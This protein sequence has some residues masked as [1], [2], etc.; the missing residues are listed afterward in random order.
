MSK[1]STKLHVSF[2]M[3]FNIKQI[4]IKFSSVL[5]IMVCDVDVKVVVNAVSVHRL[6][7]IY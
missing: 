4:G 3:L 7:V 1:N 5:V 6:K 2:E